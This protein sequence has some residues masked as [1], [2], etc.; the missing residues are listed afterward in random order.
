MKLFY[1][2]IVGHNPLYERFNNKL[3][4]H[5][6]REAR[7]Q[8]ILSELLK[9]G[10]FDAIECEDA[11]INLNEYASSNYIAELI[12][13]TRASKDSDFLPVYPLQ[14]AKIGTDNQYFHDTYTPITS[15][16]FDAARLSAALTKKAAIELITADAESAYALC[17]PPGH[18][19]GSEYAM[20][21]CYLN[22]AA[23]AAIELVQRGRV[24]I[25]DIDYHHGNGTQEYFYSSDRVLFASIHAHPAY[26]FPYVSGYS[27]E[28]G[29]GV[30]YGFNY[31]QPLLP[32]ATRTEYFTA[33]DET[34]RIISDYNPRYLVVSLGV[35]THIAD[36]VG[37]FALELTDFDAIGKAIGELNIPTLF[38]QEGGYNIDTLGIL[39]C[40]VLN[41]FN[42]R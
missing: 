32:S 35:D 31:N 42:E 8:V 6:E 25:L 1:P 2:A 12:R 4:Q 11:A 21:Y 20:G 9:A 33:L 14:E 5:S 27:F 24:A 28:R 37:G 13:L 38:V 39:V 19:A 34:L 15:T 30:G 3:I 22:N 26:K 7:V 10:G 36:P 17:R 41:G 40:R 18:H 29:V 16:T 23:V